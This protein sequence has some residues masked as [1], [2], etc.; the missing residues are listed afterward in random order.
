LHGVEALE[1]NG[2]GERLAL[3]ARVF[4]LD[5]VE[6]VRLRLIELLLLAHLADDLLR[7]ADHVLVERHSIRLQLISYN[8]NV[9]LR[10]TK[11]H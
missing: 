8:S 2:G 11:T 3:V 7:L 6:D 4:V 9:G 5:C 1:E 10:T